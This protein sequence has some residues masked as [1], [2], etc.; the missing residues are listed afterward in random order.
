MGRAAPD[1][2]SGPDPG[3]KRNVAR[4]TPFQHSYR[5]ARA[6]LPGLDVPRQATGITALE[7]ARAKLSGPPG[8]NWVVQDTDPQ[9]NNHG[10]GDLALLP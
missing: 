8:I 4:A 1:V 5:S 9:G 6:G 2:E 10:W 7:F 3:N